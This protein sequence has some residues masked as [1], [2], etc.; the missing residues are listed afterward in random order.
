MLNFKREINEEIAQ[1]DYFNDPEA[2]DKEEQLKAMAVSCDAIIRLA[3]RYAEKAEDMATE[4][5]EPKRIDELLQI[6][7]VCRRVP[8]HK[9]RDFWEAIQMYWFV[10]LGVI[11]E[12]NGWD[13]FNPGHFDQHLAPF[14]KNDLAAGTLTRDDAKEL[15][16]LFLDKSEQSAC[17]A[18]GGCYR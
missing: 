9:P 6:A 13:A 7:E 1:L 14:Y 17:P 11:I 18:K 15:F 2:T 16:K 4:E 3:E 5:K 12:L 8:A 10:H